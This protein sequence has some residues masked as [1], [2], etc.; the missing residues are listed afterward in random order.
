MVEII[1][2][3]VAVFFNA[4]ANS[5]WNV[6]NFWKCHIPKWIFFFLLTGYVA[7]NSGLQWYWIIVLAIFCHFLW[8]FTAKYIGKMEN[9][10]SLWKKYLPDLIKRLWKLIKGV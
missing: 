2:I 8:I 4:L 5:W 10:G 7:L 9:A 6:T 3:I 1:I